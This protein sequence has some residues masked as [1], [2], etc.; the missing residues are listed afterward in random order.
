MDKLC[1]KCNQLKPG[2]SLCGS[3]NRLN[4]AGEVF[5][6]RSCGYTNQADLNGAINIGTIALAGLLSQGYQA[7]KQETVNTS[8]SAL[9][10]G[11]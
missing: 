4:R 8:L 2:C 10:I 1:T 11:R 7:L 3:V 9:A 5:K 6:C